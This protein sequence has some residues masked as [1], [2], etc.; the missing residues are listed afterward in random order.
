MTKLIRYDRETKDFAAYVD[1]NLIGFYVTRF[2]AE[3]ACDDYVYE[4]LRRAA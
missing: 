2:E 1:G 3:R 4:Q